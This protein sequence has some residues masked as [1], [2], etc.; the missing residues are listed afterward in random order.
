MKEETPSV[1]D[2]ASTDVIKYYDFTKCGTGILDQKISKY[3]CKS[4]T[5]WLKIVHSYFL[6]DT[7]HCNTLTMYAMKHGKPH[8]K[9]SAFD[10]VW[11][12]VISLVKQFIDVRPTVCLGIGLR[13]K[14]SVILGININE[15]VEAEAYEYPRFGETKQRCNI[16]LFYISG[17]N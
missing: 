5:P 8:G 7:V 15:N 12:L 10:I 2:N 3:L 17:Q 6:L 13:S 16:C 1:I 11:D 9:I 4:V 14:I